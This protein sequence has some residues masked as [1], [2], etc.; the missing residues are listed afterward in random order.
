MPL[1][2]SKAILGYSRKCTRRLVSSDVYRTLGGKHAK[3]QNNCKLHLLACY[4][5]DQ[6]HLLSANR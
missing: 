5:L 4:L 2:G 6:V 3:K 1:F